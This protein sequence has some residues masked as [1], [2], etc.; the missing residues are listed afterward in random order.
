MSIQLVAKEYIDHGWA[1]VPLVAGEKRAEGSWPKKTYKPSDFNP[2]DNI[3]GKCGEPSGWRVDVDLDCDEAIAAARL[4]LPVTGL[5]HG[6]PGKPDSHYW[7]LCEGIKTTQFTDIKD[8]SGKNAMLIEVRSTGG[9]TVLPPSTHPSGEILS[10]SHERAPLAMSPDDLY[11]AAR[12]VALV[13]LLARHWPGSGAR[14]AA[15]GHLAGFLCKAGLEPDL[16]VRLI[17]MSAQLAK[18]PD[19][20]DRV[21]FARN[22]CGK[23]TAGEATTGGPKLAEELGEPVVN[24]MRSWLRMGDSD[25]I[26]E[27]NTR[28][29][30][31]RMGKDDVIGREDDPSED[32]VFQKV[33][34]LYSEYANRKIKVGEK[35]D[36]TPEFKPLFLAW[37]ESRQ[38]RSYRRVVF[39]PPPRKAD[40]LDYNLWSGY[41]LEPQKG[42]CALF[43]DHLF[44]VICSGN[45]GHYDYL[46]NLLALT[47]QEPGSPSEVATTLRGKPGT[48]KGTFVRALGKIF[49]KHFAHLDKVDDLLGHFNAAVS[50]KVV[51]FADEAF[52]AGDK[53]EVGALKRMITEPTL[54][55]TRKGIDSVSEVNHIHLFMATNEHWVIP[56]QLDERRFFALYVS[57]KR[58]RDFAYFARVEAS[59]N[60]GGL[61]AFLYELMDR[62]IDRLLLRDV[63]Q[64]KE[65][66]NQQSL[67]LEPLLEWWQDCLYEGRIGNVG[68][69]DHGWIPVAAVFDNYL[70]WIGGRKARPLSKIEFARRMMDYLTADEK[71]ACRKIAGE[72]TRCIRLR[73]IDEARNVFDRGLAA[74]GDWPADAANTA[75]SAIPF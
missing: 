2:S 13:S 28:H 48:G 54:Q 68:W 42:D 46:M 12:D 52:W 35:K 67:S 7:Y 37:L 53:R 59:L 24:R 25:Q 50:G 30:W 66:R 62:R 74:P 15:V 16:V 60:A 6:R 47:V 19:V 33:R 58:I 39:A 64:T 21:N 20:H 17:E 40:E 26:E 56:A 3:A 70:A 44:H 27:M 14:H 29:F 72:P 57:D 73:P 1:V 41:A 63:P 34:S 10:W 49:G 32:V 55:I 4:L 51:V 23:F 5:I 38:R 65:L 31:V 69:T 11:M 36:G 43:L 9:Y 75:Q 8:T 71:S 18:D 22:T 45:S 61:Q